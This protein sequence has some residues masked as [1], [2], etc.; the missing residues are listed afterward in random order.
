MQIGLFG[1]VGIL[2]VCTAPFIGRFVD[3]LASPWYATLASMGV[4]IGF[5]VI[6]ITAGTRSVGAVVVAV[7]GLSLSV[8]SVCVMFT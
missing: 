8:L 4:L 2:G 3:T 1:L 6:M 7:F 5:L